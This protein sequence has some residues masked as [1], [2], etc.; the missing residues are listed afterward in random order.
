MRE[1]DA[2]IRVGLADDHP[3]FR[4]GLRALLHTEPGIAVV[5]EA[6]DGDAAV[7]MVRGQPLDILLLDLS[8]PRLNGIDVLREIQGARVKS[9]LFAAEIARGDIVAALRLGA[10]G[11]LLKDSLPALVFKCIHSVMDGQYWVE[12]DVVGDLLKTVAELEKGASSRIRLTAR[13]SEVL[14]LIAA[15]CTNRD[16][17]EKFQVSTDTVKHHVTNIFDKTGVSNRVE[18]A[19]FAIHHDLV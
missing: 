5:G 4:Q 1:Q 3:I 17:A 9:V 13:E 8:M 18:L 10:R 11:V 12:R 19:L 15:G 14:A 7:R 2:T 16:I 6:S